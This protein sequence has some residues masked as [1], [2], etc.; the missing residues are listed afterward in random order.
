[1][2][3]TEIYRL[4]TDPGEIGSTR[5]AWRGAMYVWDD[6]ARR[7]FGLDGFPFSDREMKAKIWNAHQ[8]VDLAPHEAIVL[9]TTMDFA[10]VR[11]RDVWRVVDA[12]ERYGSEHPDSSLAEQAQILRGAQFPSASDAVAWLQTSVSEFWGVTWGEGED[13]TIWYDPATGDKH[14]DV[15][16]HVQEQ[17]P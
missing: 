16:D 10:T 3:R 14:F 8:H 7:Y 4:G 11:A 1:M 9:L 5:N 15:F 12:F 17:S 2:S 13:E 6:I